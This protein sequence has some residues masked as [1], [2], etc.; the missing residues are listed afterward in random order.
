MTNQTESLIWRTPE[1]DRAMLVLLHIT[2]GFAL[3][4][5]FIESIL[6]TVEGGYLHLLFIASDIFWVVA[7]IVIR[8]RAMRKI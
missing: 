3:F 1:R 6:A 8:R 5:V 4:G 2:V 7:L